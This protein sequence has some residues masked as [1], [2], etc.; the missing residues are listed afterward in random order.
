MFLPCGH[1]V[2]DLAGCTL[3]MPAVSVGNVGQLAIDLII[4]TLN[5]HKIGYFYTDCL[6]PMVGNNPYATAEE[7]S[8]ELSINAE[9]YALPSKKLV[10]LQFR[11]IFPFRSVQSLSR[12]RLFA[13]PWTVAY[14][15]SP[16]MGF[17]RQEYWS[18]LP[19][20]SHSVKTCFPG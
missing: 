6:V 8:A 9:V 2:P 11:S 19:F 7:N 18:G 15:A 12:V 20:Q 1:S 5:M 17:S 10:T 4:S 3:L 14:Q 16:S 13:T